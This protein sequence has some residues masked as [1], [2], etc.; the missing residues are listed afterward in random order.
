M[1]HLQTYKTPN[2]S[3]EWKKNLSINFD[4]CLYFLLS[5][6]FSMKA[7]MNE[8]TCERRHCV[9]CCENTLANRLLC[10][11]CWFTVYY[12]YYYYYRCVE[13]TGRRYCYAIEDDI[14][15][16]R[17]FSRWFGSVDSKLL[18]FV[19]YVMAMRFSISCRIFQIPCPTGSK[20]V[21]III[22]VNRICSV[23]VAITQRKR[24][25][26][27]SMCFLWAKSEL[28]NSMFVQMRDTTEHECDASDI[29]LSPSNIRFFN[30]Q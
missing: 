26:M 15:V 19:A 16:L 3:I 1:S 10:S 14:F 21:W 18:Y 6:T 25:K 17:I 13:S 8:K 9:Y 20:G 2:A 12:Y 28:R 30:G 24:I 22:H 23:E 4:C 11:S 27:L 5:A 29:L 7:T